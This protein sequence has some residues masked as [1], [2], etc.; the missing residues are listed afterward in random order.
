MAENLLQLNLSSG[1]VRC[2]V[3]QRRCSLSEGQAGYCE[4][5]VNRKG[6]IESLTYGQVS[7]IL[8][9]PIE[10]KPLFHY[11]PGS[12]WLSLGSVGC[13]FRC[14]GCQ[15]YEIAHAEPARKKRMTKTDYLAPEEL[16]NLARRNNCKGI[17]WTYN[18]PAIWLEY[19]RDGARL[20]REAGLLTNYVTNGFM[21]EE[22]MDEIGPYLDSYRVDLKGFFPETYGRIA[23]VPDPSGIFQGVIRAREKWGMW[24]EII[25]NLIPG[26][27]DSEEEIRAL[28]RWIRQELDEGIPWH[29]TRFFPYF[30]LSGLNPTPVELLERARDIGFEEG[31][32]Y[33]Y[34]GNVLEHTGIN[35]YCAG[36]KN[37]L[38]ERDK[39]SVLQNLLGPEGQCPFCGERIPGRF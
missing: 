1:R 14:P 28:A 24:V 16:V 34:L 23:H 26:F 15:N 5:R 9:S 7:S 6:R 29:L 3:C 27:N 10:K 4:A 35:T 32:E 11:Y 8:V 30:E 17:S 33:V 20:A 19:T 18:E 25:T 13:N 2:L 22:A 38:I 37:L 39:F 36:C 31:L 12:L 21:T